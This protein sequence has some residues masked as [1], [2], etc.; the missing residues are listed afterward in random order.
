MEGEKTLVFIPLFSFS[1]SFFSGFYGRL[2]RNDGKK[3]KEK[4]EE[5]GFLEIVNA[6]F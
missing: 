4:D 5:E 3:R 2:V 6:T 1:F